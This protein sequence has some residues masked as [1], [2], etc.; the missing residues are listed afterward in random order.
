MRRAAGAHR[1]RLGAVP[2]QRIIVPKASL[3][4]SFALKSSLARPHGM[5][6]CVGGTSGVQVIQHRIGFCM[7]PRAVVGLDIRMERRKLARRT[8][9]ERV[10]SLLE[11]S[12]TFFAV[13]LQVNG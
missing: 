11:V 4:I 13:F 6:A 3:V 8:R 10:K 1:R 2:L 12:G 5:V 9:D 7:A